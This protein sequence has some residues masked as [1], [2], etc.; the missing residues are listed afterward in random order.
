MTART[1]LREIR[2]LTDTLPRPILPIRSTFSDQDRATVNSWK[3]YLKWEEGNP[4]VIE[5]QE[6]LH[7]RIG[8]ALR[9]CLAEMRHFPELWWVWRWSWLMDRHYAANH[10][11]K[12][13]KT[14]DAATILAAGVET[15]PKR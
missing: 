9:R 4:L 12:L 3:T 14:E 5:D 15:C 6:V 1:A 13:H 10:Y 8:Y 7:G 2:S 11:M